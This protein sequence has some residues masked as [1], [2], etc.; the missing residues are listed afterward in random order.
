MPKSKRNTK[1]V[2]SK[3]T[4]AGKERKEKLL[5][6]IR[7]AIDQYAN[8]FVW[9]EHNMRNNTMKDLKTKDWSHSKFFYGKVKVMAIALGKTPALEAQPNLHKLV[10]FLS[11]HVGLLFTNKDK[12]EVKEFFQSFSAYHYSTAG[13]IATETVTLEPGILEQFPHSIEPHLR[14]LGMP[15][16]LNKGSVELTRQ[17]IV[18]Q[19]G[20]SLQPNQCRI[21][22]LLG[23]QMS[24]FSISL[25]CCWSKDGS[26]ESFLS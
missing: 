2:L 26:F 22:K 18:C 17:H 16:K 12:S 3:V 23:H 5:N 24:K 4:K 11:G 20:E 15:T 13:D 1:V 10:P 21:L 14:E 25:K 7:L 9:E 8:V 6:N 19:D